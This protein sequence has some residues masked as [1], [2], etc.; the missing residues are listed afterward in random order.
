MNV[1]AGDTGVEP[2][3]GDPE[4]PVLPLHQSPS[5]MTFLIIAELRM[6]G[7]LRYPY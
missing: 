3:A 5:D 7:K 2:V 4:S 6:C 1:L